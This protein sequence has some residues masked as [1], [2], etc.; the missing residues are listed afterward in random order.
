L[1]IDDKVKIIRGVNMK[2]IVIGASGT[3]GSAVFNALQDKH[4]I[5]KAT[6]NGDIKIDLSNP[7]SIKDMYK[8]VS[9]FDAVLCAAGE[10]NFGPLD[11]LSDENFQLSLQ[12]K[13]MGQINLVRFG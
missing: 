1:K 2:I 5:V 4:E 7:E 11:S 6:R 8:K 12:N 13:L 9:N 10:A 3:I